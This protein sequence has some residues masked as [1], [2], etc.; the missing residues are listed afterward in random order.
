MKGKQGNVAGGGGV[1][2]W[3]IP[4]F[5]ELSSESR[6]GKSEQS[7]LA[8]AESLWRVAKANAMGHK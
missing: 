7:R 2:M 4:N 3:R 8:G 6:V 1:C 5:W